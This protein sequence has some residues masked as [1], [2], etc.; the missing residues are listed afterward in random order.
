MCENRISKAMLLIPATSR[1]LAPFTIYDHKN[2]DVCKWM[3]EIRKFCH[4]SCRTFLRF[5]A[6]CASRQ[7]RH[8]FERSEHVTDLVTKFLSFYV[9]FR[10][11][12]TDRIAEAALLIVPISKN[13]NV[14][15]SFNFIKRRANCDKHNESLQFL[16]IIQLDDNHSTGMNVVLTRSDN[17]WL[18]NNSLRTHKTYLLERQTKF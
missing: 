8:E 17:L 1:G 12:E 16:F 11:A 18:K 9:I 4:F 6:I 15:S 7:C 14:V 13:L 10:N 3:Q 5:H 2:F